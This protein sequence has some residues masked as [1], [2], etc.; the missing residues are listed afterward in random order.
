MKDRRIRPIHPFAF[1]MLIRDLVR[2]TALRRTDQ[3]FGCSYLGGL[4]SKAS[5]GIPLVDIRHIGRSM[6]LIS[7]FSFRVRFFR[8]F[9]FPSLFRCF[10][11]LLVDGGGGAGV[12][13]TAYNYVRRDC[14]EFAEYHT[15]NVQNLSA[16]CSHF[17]PL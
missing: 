1:R 17:L 5:R 15:Q 7:C 9:D 6:N 11:Y 4:K 16:I 12:D 3:P 2:A 13:S 14:I 10:S 8:P